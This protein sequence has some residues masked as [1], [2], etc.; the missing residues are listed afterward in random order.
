MAL[1]QFIF[2]ISVG[3]PGMLGCFQLA[4]NND[5]AAVRMTSESRVATCFQNSCA[6]LHAHHVCMNDPSAPHPLKQSASSGLFV[7]LLIRDGV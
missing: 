1:I 4:A 2:V 6:I 7:N 3:V 5:L